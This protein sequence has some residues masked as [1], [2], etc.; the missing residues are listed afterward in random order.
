MSSKPQPGPSGRSDHG[1]VTL[2]PRPSAPCLQQGAISLL[3]LSATIKCGIRG[4][5]SGGVLAISTAKPRQVGRAGKPGTLT[6]EHPPTEGH[7]YEEVPASLDVPPTRQP[8]WPFL[9]GS[10][11]R[12]VFLR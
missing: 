7:A 2:R 6:G 11:G 4:S 10:A 8:A 12:G 1:Q 3:G 5:A 9:Q